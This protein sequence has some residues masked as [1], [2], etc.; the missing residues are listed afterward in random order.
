MPCRREVR[1]E[2]ARAECK[3]ARRRWFVIV[4]TLFM[5]VRLAR[6]ITPNRFARAPRDGSGATTN[7]KL[8]FTKYAAGSETGLHVSPAKSLV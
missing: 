7:G 2:E 8:L 4:H 6:I 5:N 1:A 3:A